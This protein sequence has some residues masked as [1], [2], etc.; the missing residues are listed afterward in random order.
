MGNVDEIF[1]DNSSHLA[2]FI[3]PDAL[4]VSLRLYCVAQ[5]CEEWNA[6]LDEDLGYQLPTCLGLKDSWDRRLC[7][8]IWKNPRQNRTF[9][10]LR[11]SKGHDVLSK[12]EKPRVF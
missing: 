3:F 6:I 1:E 8:L 11:V 7:V 5:L 4:N 10:S 2:T 9:Q 12:G